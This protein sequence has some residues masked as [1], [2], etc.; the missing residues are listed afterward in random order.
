M[1]ESGEFSQSKI[2]LFLDDLR[3]KFEGPIVVDMLCYLRMYTELAIR[4]KAALI[5]R[6]NGLRVAGRGAHPGKI[7]GTPLP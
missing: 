2:G 7:R 1:I 4:A 6:E 3:E 5:A